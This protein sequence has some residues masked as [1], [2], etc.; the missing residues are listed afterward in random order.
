MSPRLVR[1]VALLVLLAILGLPK[2]A[3]ACSCM[4][5]GP[6]SKV[7][8]GKELIVL[9]EVMDHYK[10]SM[11]VR[12][13]EVPQGNRREKDDQDLGRYRGL[14]QALCQW[15]SRWHQVV[16]G[17]VS[18]TREDSGNKAPLARIRLTAWPERIR[19]LGLRGLL[20]RGP[21]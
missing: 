6:F 4:W 18:L 3:F 8:P 15:F 17:G 21:R 5:A 19:D 10:N 13:I 2:P 11:D 16:I 9:G 1:T 20:A 7:A 14:M 12:V